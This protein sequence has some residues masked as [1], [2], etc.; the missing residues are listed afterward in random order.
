[1]PIEATA[2][3][4]KLRRWRKLARGSASGVFEIEI[5]VAP[6]LIDHGRDAPAD[7]E[8]GDNAKPNEA[9]VIAQV[10]EP[11]PH[12]ALLMELL[13]DHAQGLDRADQQSNDDRHERDI[14]IVV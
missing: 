4:P 1:M 10:R 8:H 13:G 6:H 11:I 2:A 5:V 14:H 12:P 7:N 9:K 3:A